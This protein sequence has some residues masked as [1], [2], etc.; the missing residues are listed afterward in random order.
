MHQIQVND[1]GQIPEAI[2]WCKEHLNKGNWYIQ[3][4]WPNPGFVFSF[5]DTRD[6][7]WF[8]LH[9]VQ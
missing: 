5:D 1:Q 8:G 3:T 9:W 4:N 6:A 2:L 7:T